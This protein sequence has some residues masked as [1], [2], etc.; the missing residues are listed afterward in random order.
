MKNF[1]KKVM[2]AILKTKI[3]FLLILFIGLVFSCKK[4]E[5]TNIESA[6]NDTIQ[7]TLDTVGP[8]VDS[9]NGDTTT[10]VQIDS[11]KK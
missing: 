10:R 9:I 4:N 3:T 11:I 2:K 7:N 8:E 5:N 6:E 1:K